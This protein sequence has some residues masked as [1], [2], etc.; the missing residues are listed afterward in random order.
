MNYIVLIRDHTGKLTATKSLNFI[1]KS[2]ERDNEVFLVKLADQSAVARII[3]ADESPTYFQND[4]ILL[5]V[6]T[7]LGD[8]DLYLTEN[9]LVLAGWA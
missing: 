6:R 3:E 1:M 8:R 5:R 4:L 2:L 9:D 7:A